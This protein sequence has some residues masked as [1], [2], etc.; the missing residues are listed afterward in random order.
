MSVAYS[1]GGPVLLDAK[2]NPRRHHAHFS[3][4]RL[5][6]DWKKMETAKRTCTFKSK[7]VTETLVSYLLALTAR[8]NAKFL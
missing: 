6:T 7:D 2:A 4:K 5:R 8:H 3:L 1:R